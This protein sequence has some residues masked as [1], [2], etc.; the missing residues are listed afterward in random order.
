MKRDEMRGMKKKIVD[1]TEWWK[2]FAPTE[3]ILCAMY[4]SVTDCIVRDPILMNVPVDDHLVHRGDGVF[5]SFKCVKGQ[6]YNLEAHLARLQRSAET[7]GLE[8]PVALDEMAQ[9]ILQ[10]IRAGGERNVLIRLLLS[11]GCGTMGVNPYACRRPE[12]YVVVYRSTLA[13]AVDFP[14]G[15]RVGVSRV[16]VKPGFLATVK[17]C[18]YL[19]NVLMKKEAVDAGLDFVVSLDEAG[20]LAEGATENI[21]IVTPEKELLMPPPER[22][23]EG[24]TARRALFLAQK[25]V[26]KGLLVCAEYR[27]ISLEQARSARE[28]HIYGTTPNVTPVIEFDAAPVGDGKPGEV[29]KQL[30]A[31]LRDEMLPESLHLTSVFDDVD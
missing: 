13:G 4:S 7:V 6:V 26:E 9:I 3:S 30:F 19:P 12:F 22:V 14:D 24:T 5:E 28:M 23:L 21:G 2:R 16:P 17:T 25:L 20:N 18:N 27:P 29:A 10:T 31:L 1:R 11:R 8:L 15:V